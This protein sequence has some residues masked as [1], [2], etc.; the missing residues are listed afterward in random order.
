MG[1][2]INQLKAAKYMLTSRKKYSEEGSVKLNGKENEWFKSFKY[3]VFLVTES[4]YMR[5]EIV[6]RKAV[7]NN[8]FA[9]CKYLKQVVV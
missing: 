4:N 2:M 7:D 9:L 8:Y 1:L 5:E 3:L 6:A